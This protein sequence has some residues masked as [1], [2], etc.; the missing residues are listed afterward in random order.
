MGAYEDRYP[1][2]YGRGEDAAQLPA[3]DELKEG[4]PP[5]QARDAATLR[6]RFGLGQPPERRDPQT[7][8]L[9]TW[10]HGPT[11]PAGAPFPTTG[12][13]TGRTAVAASP[14]IPSA[15]NYRGIGPRNYVRSP[16]RIWEDICDRLTDNAFID[17]S[18]IEVNVNGSEVLLRGSVDSMIALRQAEAIVHQAIGVSHIRNELAVRS[19]AASAASTASVSGPPEDRINR[20]IAAGRR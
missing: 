20:A 9:A 16:A 13:T 15:G 14:S 18:D 5:R 10:G 19:F 1:D 8:N 12:P 3:K 4:T 6:A 11:A 2:A 17:A 7:E